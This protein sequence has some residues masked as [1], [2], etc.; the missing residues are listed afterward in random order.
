[1]IPKQKRIVNK[2]LCDSYREMRCAVCFMKGGGLICGHHIKT[3]GSGGH[4]HSKNLMPLCQ[5][6]HREVHDKGLEWFVNEYDTAREYL[7]WLGFEIHP[8][9]IA[10]PKIY[11]KD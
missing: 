4:D 7:E 10:W 1:M 8:E 11:I 5:Q 9:Y 6:H 3:K 2:E